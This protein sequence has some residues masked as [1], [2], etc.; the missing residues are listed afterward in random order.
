MRIIVLG[1]LVISIITACR[2]KQKI[3]RDLTQ[4]KITIGQGGGFTGYYIDYIIYGTGK[5]EKYTSKDEKTAVLKPMPV[6]SVRA[7]VNRM[8]QINFEGI[9]LDQPGNMS[10]YL[11]LQEPD[12]THKVRW[13]DATPPGDL[14]NLYNRIWNAVSKE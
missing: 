5:L 6:D 9:V 1:A 7:W 2:S 14:H 3:T 11:E 12:K 8:D 13:G 10:Y 4:V